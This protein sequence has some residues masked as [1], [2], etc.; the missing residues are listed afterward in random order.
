MT[1]ALVTGGASGI[2]AACALRLAADG[3]TVVVAD[4]NA[5][6]AKEVAEKITA[7]GGSALARTLDVT[8]AEAVAALVHDLST[9]DDG[10]G[11]VVNCAGI[12]GP[13]SALGDYPIAEYQRVMRIT[14]DGTFYTM[15][16]ALPVMAAAGRGV[17]VNFA[18][19]A[20]HTGNSLHSAYVAA[21]HAVIGLTKTAAREYGEHGV[22]VVSV[23]P[24]LIATPMTDALPTEIT[25]RLV[26]KLPTPRI[27]RPEEVA[28]LVGFLASDAAA[29]INGSDHAIDGG[30]LAS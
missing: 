15:H 12:S 13:I 2:G 5:T 28:A 3:H 1:Q 24:G 27:G 8:D 26:R 21:K 4:V 25:E 19:V 7:G 16:A 9:M 23:S 10:L 20:G 14:L 30:Y 11:V 17:I 29:Y 22:R 6:G 18:S